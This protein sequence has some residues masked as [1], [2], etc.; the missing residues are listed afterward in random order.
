MVQSFY[1]LGVQ[2]KC[3]TK[4]V[5]CSSNKLFI[6]QIPRELELD[7]LTQIPKGATLVQWQ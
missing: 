2:S 6:E 3:Y 4:S 7:Q 5:A 1:R